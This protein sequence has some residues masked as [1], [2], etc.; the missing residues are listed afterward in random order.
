MKL[1]DLI[2]VYISPQK[3]NYKEKELFDKP[4]ISTY[5]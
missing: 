5:N 3:R 1:N 4:G 2:K